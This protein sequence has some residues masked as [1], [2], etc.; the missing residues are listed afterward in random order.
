MKTF[1]FAWDI[2]TEIKRAQTAMERKM[3]EIK[4]KDNK[5]K[6]KPNRKKQLNT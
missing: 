2:V 5:M 4:L 3:L 1:T 6:Q